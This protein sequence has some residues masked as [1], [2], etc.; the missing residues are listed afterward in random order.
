MS[1]TLQPYAPFYILMISEFQKGDF[2]K[3]FQNYQF[4]AR[5]NFDVFL[6]SCRP[7]LQDTLGGR[8]PFRVPKKVTFSLKIQPCFG[9]K[10]CDALTRHLKIN[11]P[12]SALK[13]VVS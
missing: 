7:Q 3:F 11:L 6:A 1:L 8:W 2:N 9:S 5:S 13:K 12:T 4:T 10:V